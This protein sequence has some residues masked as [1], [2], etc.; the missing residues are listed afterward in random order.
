MGE[1]TAGCASVAGCTFMETAGVSADAAKVA[2]TSPGAE[3]GTEED[4]EGDPE[5]LYADVFDPEFDVR[6]ALPSGDGLDAK[7]A[8]FFSTSR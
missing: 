5:E 8:G 1:F 4:A 3:D 7:V 6:L 2:G